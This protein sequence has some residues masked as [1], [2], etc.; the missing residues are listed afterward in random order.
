MNITDED[1]ESIAI[2][3]CRIRGIE[4]ADTNVKVGGV[5]MKKYQLAASQVRDV[6]S[7]VEAAQQ[8]AKEKGPG[9]MPAPNRVFS[10]EN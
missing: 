1:I 7:I 8:I 4:D 10:R 5:T 6:L 3:F 2:R 9:P